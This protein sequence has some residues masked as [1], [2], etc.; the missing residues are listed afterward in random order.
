M[1][2]SWIELLHRAGNYSELFSADRA[3]ACLLDIIVTMLEQQ[4]YSFAYLYEFS[5]Q[6]SL[7]LIYPSSV[8]RTTNRRITKKKTFLAISRNL[9]N[10][11]TDEKTGLELSPAHRISYYK[12]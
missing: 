12:K 9:P 8:P 1:T 6:T 5:A 7:I 3:V 10:P 11:V 2:R 4:N